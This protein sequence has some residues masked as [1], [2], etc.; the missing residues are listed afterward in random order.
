MKQRRFRRFRIVFV[1]FNVV[2]FLFLCGCA[3]AVVVLVVVVVVVV[4]ML[5]AD[6]SRWIALLRLIVAEHFACVSAWVGVE[7][8]VKLKL[9][10]K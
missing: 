1:V 6:R 8:G 4:V 9:K 5:D 7:V 2:Q 3:H 10:W